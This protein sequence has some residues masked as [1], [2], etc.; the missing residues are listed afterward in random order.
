MIVK[1]MTSKLVISVFLYREEGT[2]QMYKWQIP[3]TYVMVSWTMLITIIILE[4]IS[5]TWDMTIVI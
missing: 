5:A 2:L 3:W 1:Y 4:A